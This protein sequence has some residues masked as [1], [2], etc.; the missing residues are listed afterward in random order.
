ME[1]GITCDNLCGVPSP[2]I[3]CG[4]MVVAAGM[5]MIQMIVGVNKWQCHEWTNPTAS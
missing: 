1:G 3:I 5:F 2:I 4:V